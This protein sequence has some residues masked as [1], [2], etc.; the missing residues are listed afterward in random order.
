MVLRHMEAALCSTV[1]PLH[2][3]AH[4]HAH[5]HKHTCAHTHTHM[6]TVSGILYTYIPVFLIVY[7]QLFV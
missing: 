2:T 1:S 4:A 5:A 7:S 3:H 6:Y